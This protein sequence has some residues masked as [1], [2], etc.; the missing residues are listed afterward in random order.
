[1]NNPSVNETT[2]RNDESQCKSLQTDRQ[3]GW[4]QGWWENWEQV[5][6]WAEMSGDC[7]A[8]GSGWKWEWER[9]RSLRSSGGQLEGGRSGELEE[10]AW[11]WAGVGDRGLLFSE[12]FSSFR[13]GCENEMKNLWFRSVSLRP[14]NILLHSKRRLLKHRQSLVR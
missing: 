10:S 2:V 5:C 8:G 14:I 6:K 7:R 1:M 13:Q 3:I 11:P 9:R 4:L 12:C